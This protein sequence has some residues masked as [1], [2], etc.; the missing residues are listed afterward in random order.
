MAI[1]NG[2]E[3]DSFDVA[4]EL[5]LLKAI[6]LKPMQQTSIFDLPLHSTI[7][8]LPLAI[9]KPKPENWFIA[10]E[11]FKFAIG[12]IVQSSKYFKNLNGEIIGFEQYGDV[13]FAIV[14]YRWY[15][16][17]ID[18]PAIATSLNLVNKTHL[19]DVSLAEDNPQPIAE[20]PQAIADNQ[21]LKI[22]DRVKV[23]KHQFMGDRIGIIQ[24]LEGKMAMVYFGATENIWCIWIGRL[25]KHV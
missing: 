11:T 5:R 6:A 24:N 14:R 23:L 20:N 10:P 1:R 12:E 22:G 13:D 15:D 7:A 25:Q 21:Q 8:D 17:V 9:I 3:R 16:S 2:R 4:A 19:S 18:Y